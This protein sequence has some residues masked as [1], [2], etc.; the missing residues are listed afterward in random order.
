MDCTR[1]ESELAAVLTGTEETE[2]RE[3]RLAALREHATGCE[4]CRGSLALLDWLAIPPEERDGSDDP[5]EAYWESFN[6]RLEVRIAEEKAAIS[7]RRRTRWALAATLAG[8]ALV[9]VWLLRPGDIR[10]A[11]ED[12]PLPGPLAERLAEADLDSM[13][14]DLAMLVGPDE[15]VDEAPLFPIDDDPEE[16]GWVFP[17]TRGLDADG[18]QRLIDWLAAEKARL[19]GGS[20]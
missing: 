13:R 14:E 17:S 5:G 16:A 11:S 19:E 20:A 12:E 9:S 1:F 15:G 3:G 8:L 18:R 10:V 6:R 2:C 7:R 4:A